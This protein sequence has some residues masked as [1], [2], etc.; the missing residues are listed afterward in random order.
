M[1]KEIQSVLLYGDSFFWGVH[2]DTGKRHASSDRIGRQL[3]NLLGPDFEVIEEGHRGR[4]MYGENGWFPERDGL[5][6][7]GPIFASH[8]PV[9]T[10]VIMLG[11]NDLNSKTL[12]RAHDIAAALD[13]YQSKIEY[14]CE[15]MGY[16][17]P[18]V[19]IVA[20]PDIDDTQLDKFRGIFAGSSEMI[21]ELSQELENKCTTMDYTFLNAGTVVKSIG[22]DGI[23]ISP[24]ENKKLAIALKNLI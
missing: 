7:F 11:T 22:A 2:P 6:Q 20:P 12:H 13:E 1:A 17:V 16:D 19:I 23:H 9:H 14:W 21:P 5:A 8:I 10:L 24:E 4:T 15:F 3:Q 18:K